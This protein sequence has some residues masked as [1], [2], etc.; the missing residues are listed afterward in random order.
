MSIVNS[1]DEL[2]F[3]SYTISMTEKD[4][5]LL[6]QG[7]D[8]F[9]RMFMKYDV[10]EKSPVDIG[11]GDRF[12]GAQIHMIEAIGKGHGKT[13]TALSG[14]FMVTKGAVSQIVTRLHKMGYV[15]KTKRKGNDKE[16]ILELT[17]KGRVAFDMH[18]KYN[19]STVAELMKLRQK[20]SP[21][22]IL[23]FLNILND[24]D[25]MLMGFVAEEKKR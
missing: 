16:I 19:E 14:Y 5:D 8:L 2:L 1:L 7:W 23:V 13:V 12:N 18:E 24:V 9:T 11:S 25:R 21:E 10:L 17:G 15:T 6:R 3:R 22:E 20:Y 4:Q